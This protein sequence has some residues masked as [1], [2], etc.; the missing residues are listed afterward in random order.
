M[1]DQMRNP[2]AREMWSSPEEIDAH[3]EEVKS[4]MISAGHS[5][6]R[7]LDS[8]EAYRQVLHES[9]TTGQ[10]LPRENSMA[11]IP[12]SPD[13]DEVEASLREQ[14]IDP[15][16]DLGIEIRT[17]IENALDERGDSNDIS[18]ENNE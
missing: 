16:S 12:I 7:I 3:I 6:E 10:P 14:G 2:S 17:H 1:T 13:D 5:D 8:V 11:M 9:Y 4:D 18:P 15:D